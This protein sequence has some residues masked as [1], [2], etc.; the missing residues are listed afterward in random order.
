MACDATAMFKTADELAKGAMGA[1][2]NFDPKTLAGADSKTI[3]ANLPPGMAGMIPK[4]V[5]MNAVKANPLAF[6]KLLPAAMLAK[7]G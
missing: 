5:D 7:L 2:K 4:G 6:A 3:M 1:L